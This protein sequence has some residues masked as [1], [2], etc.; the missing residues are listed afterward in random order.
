[1]ARPARGLRELEYGIQAVPALGK[2][3]CLLEIFDALSNDPDT[4][5]AQ[6][7]VSRPG[8]RQSRG[9]WTTKILALTDALGNLVRF[10]LLPGQR[11][12]TVGVARLIKG[13]AFGGLI[14]DKAFDV[15]WIV[16][17]LDARGAQAVISQHPRRTSRP[18]R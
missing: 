11:Y 1:L 7:G 15:D 5:R 10:E 17:D 14:A 9:G 6:K 12:D 8:H 4:D 3:R 13:V 16:A 2:G 18:P